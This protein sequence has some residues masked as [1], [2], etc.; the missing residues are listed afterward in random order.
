MEGQCR[1]KKGTCQVRMGRRRGLKAERRLFLEQREGAQ[2]E[3]GG[4]ARGARAGRRPRPR[5]AVSSPAP[6]YPAGALGRAGGGCRARWPAP[7]RASEVRSSGSFY[8]SDVV[9]PSG[10]Q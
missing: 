9:S 10:P 2:G 8:Q 6:R 1:R 7:A 5:C 4:G 3:A